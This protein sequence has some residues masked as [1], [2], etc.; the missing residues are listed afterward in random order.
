VLSGGSLLKALAELVDNKGVEFSKWHIAYADERNV[1]HSSEDSNHKGAK[2][3][4]L[5]KVTQTF[6]RHVLRLLGNS[7]LFVKF[8]L[9]H[10]SWY[11]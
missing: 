6:P 8:L 7:K 5:S 2:D 10:V 3:V 4:F 9:L 11:Q 1:A